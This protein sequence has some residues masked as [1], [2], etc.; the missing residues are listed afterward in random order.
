MQIRIQDLNLTI[1]VDVTGRDLAFSARFNVDRLRTVTIKLCD[2]ALDIQ[3]D[4]GH[5]LLDTGDGGKLVLY[6]GDLDAAGCRARQGRQQDAAKGVAERRSV[7]TLQRL[8]Y[9]FTVGAVFLQ[10]FAIYTGLFDFDH[11]RYPPYQSAI[12]IGK[13]R[14]EITWSTTRR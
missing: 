6:A 9:K 3:H 2:D 4:L 8:Y 1:G 13:M 5:I 7:T 11:L 10:H 14:A 12:N